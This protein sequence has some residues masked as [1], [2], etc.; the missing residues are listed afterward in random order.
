MSGGRGQGP[1]AALLHRAPR[2]GAPGRR[3]ARPRTAGIA[4]QLHR[5]AAAA[6][7]GGGAGQVL[8][9]QAAAP[10]GQGEAGPVVAAVHVLRVAGGER[11][12]A[13]QAV[14]EGCERPTTAA[15]SPCAACA[16]HAAARTAANRAAR[17]LPRRPPPAG[18]PRPARGARTWPYRLST[19]PSGLSTMR[20]NSASI[21]SMVGSAAGGWWGGA[22]ACAAPE[23][24]RHAWQ[25][26]A[27]RHVPGRTRAG[28]RTPGTDTGGRSPTPPPPAPAVLPPPTWQR[29]VAGQRAR[30]ALPGARAAAG[31]A[32]AAAGGQRVCSGRVPG[33]RGGVGARRRT[34]PPR[35][36]L[37]SR[38]HTAKHCWPETCTSWAPPAGRRRPSTA[39]VPT[40]RRADRGRATHPK[41]APP[42]PSRR[43]RRRSAA[44]ACAP[45]ARGRAGGEGGGRGA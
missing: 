45:A 25:Q 34:A 7:G 44:C 24:T 28:E 15:C 29:G 4:G 17:R 26:P 1:A 12:S 10:E 3:A 39:H 30:A 31:G 38:R 40:G 21:S 27:P 43:T 14:D 41:S 36:R 8:L 19:R 35:L 20:Q 2:L 37:H 22:R 6:G 23:Q 32:G 16:A 11:A 9:Q 33:G 42:A 5:R 13:A 18:E